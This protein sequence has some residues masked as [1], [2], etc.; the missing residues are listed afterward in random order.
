M[1]SPTEDLYTAFSGATH[2]AT[3][4]L[5]QVL[6]R[7]QELLEREKSAQVL[8]F[9]DESGKQVDFDLRG[10][11]EEVLA[12]LSP[13][14]PKKG[15]GRPSLGVVCREVS[16]L[17]R[18]WEWLE[19][20][21]ARSSG[22]LRRLVDAAIKNESAE[23]RSRR[24]VEAAG[25]LMW[26]LAGNLE[27]FEEASRAL[28]ARRWP[29]FSTRI[30]AWP[31]DLRRHLEWM[32]EPVKSPGDGGGAPAPSPVLLSTLRAPAGKAE[33][34]GRE[35]WRLDAL[36]L[37]AAIRRGE[38]SAVAAVESCLERIR[39]VN[40]EVRAVTSLFADQ[41]RAQAAEL[42]RRRAAGQESGPLAGVPFTVKENLDVAGQPTTQGIPAL[43]DA[44]APLDCPLV[45][46]LRDAGAIP[47]GHTNMPDLSLR[48]HTH[49]QLFGAT[50]NPWDPA[51]SPGGSSGGEG[52]ALAT[53]LSALGLGN[54]AGG[55]VRIPALLN[56][57]AALKP[58]YGR[59]PSDRS[60]GPRDQSLASQTIPVDGIL[61]RSVADLHLCF[62]VLAGPDPRDP[63]V[64]P[65]PLFGPE[66]GKPVRLAVTAD[67]GGLGVEPE[68]RR[69]VERAAEVLAREGYEVEA[70][71]PP[72]IPEILE[73]CGRMIMTEFHQ[74]WPLLERLLGPAGRRYLELAMRLYRP[75]DL[76]GYLGLTA[77]RQGLQR[78]WAGFLERYPLVLGPVFTLGAVPVD[79]DI[80][81][82]EEHRR[83]ALGLRLCTASSFIGVPAVAVPA[84]LAGGLPQGVQLLSRPYRE[85]LCLRA[86]AC[87]EAALGRL[88]PLDPR[89]AGPQNTCSS[90]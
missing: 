3:G 43:K 14:A 22:T 83:L 90:T 72:R 78:E 47:I 62:Q 86:A 76:E 75:A 41:A 44:V 70:A 19:S 52:A 32:L 61:A 5:A 64:A 54:D 29:D 34:R 33:L 73:A 82:P 87:L 10:T 2:V 18:H 11:V 89:R 79:Y 20:Q 45:K 55:S 17:P 25:R 56:G 15:P 67:P 4:T 21:P 68:A 24:R 85:D 8:I 58:G 37:A 36:D 66:P 53:G 39:A 40:P 48:F 6:P 71:D 1:N 9:D 57:V 63:R 12:R 30:A 23:S 38:L 65:A 42:D 84:G 7:V 16:L 28:Y 81:G 74:S 60:V 27:G 77:L 26:S 46:R 88:A 31:E 59:L 51:L 80:R 49:S 35:P 50:R 13:P 69:A